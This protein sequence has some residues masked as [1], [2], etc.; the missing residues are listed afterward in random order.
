MVFDDVAEKF[1]ATG[2][3]ERLKRDEELRVMQRLPAI[4]KGEP[5]NN[6]SILVF[7]GSA[8][9]DSIVLL[10]VLRKLKEL[11]PTCRIVVTVRPFERDF[12]Y[13]VGE[14]DLLINR[15]INLKHL[16]KV[17]YMVDFSSMAGNKDF[18]EL[19]MQQYYCKKLYI[20]WENLNPRHYKLQIPK[21]ALRHMEPVIKN[22]R[23]E[24]KKPIVLLCPKSPAWVR[25]MPMHIIKRLPQEGKKFRFVIAQPSSETELTEEKLSKFGYTVLN[26]YMVNL[27]YFKALVSYVD[28]VIS[29]D[30]GCFHIAG[31][32]E[33]PVLGIFNT[34]K[35]Q[36]RNYYPKALCLQ[37]SY[38]SPLCTAPCQLSFVQASEENPKGMCAPALLNNAYHKDAPPC[39]HTLD[40]KNYNTKGRRATLIF[41]CHRVLG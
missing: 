32:L 22:I 35:C 19:G 40:T 16:P 37:V 5:L 26:R 41:V 27:S 11:Y 1:L 24:S 20:D 38:S 29:V 30:T 9:G 21:E 17:D 34:F 10:P 31:S 13:G 25:R 2:S 3:F 39:M 12:Y 15:V 6:R 8:L 36:H 14:V 7:F 18:L 33:K 28:A 23:K 4:Y